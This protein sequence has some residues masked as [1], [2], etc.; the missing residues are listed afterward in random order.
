M[1][2]TKP[3]TQTHKV[4][5]SI[6]LYLQTQRVNS[7]IQ[8]IETQTYTGKIKKYIKEITIKEQN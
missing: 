4:N 1:W 2:A 8:I 3:H 5:I 7:N 6:P